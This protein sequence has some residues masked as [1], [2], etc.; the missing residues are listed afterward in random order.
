MRSSLVVFL[1][2]LAAVTTGCSTGSR[3]SASVGASDPPASEAASSASAP[4]P[5]RVRLPP[6]FPVAPGAV[7]VAM[8]NGD[9][10]LVGSWSADPGSSAYDYYI[11]ALP[12]AGY[13]IVGRYPG[14]A[15]AVI[16][17]SLPDASVWQVV[18]HPAADGTIAIE[19]RLDRP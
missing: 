5:E 11:A 10:G 4:P 18:M 17:F 7:A 13:P 19:V 14:G 1:A 8:P 6:G 2:L 12:A 16:R 9:P 15:A 3:E